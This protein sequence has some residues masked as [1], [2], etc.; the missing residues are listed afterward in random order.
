MCV[1]HCLIIRYAHFTES[2]HGLPTLRAFSGAEERFI[3]QNLQKVDDANVAELYLWSAQ[4]WLGFRLN[5]LGAVV[6]GTCGVYIWYSGSMNPAI[7]GLV[8]NY[9]SDF[10]AYVAALIT[11]L[12]TME[13]SMNAVERAGEFCALPQE[14]VSEMRVSWS[15]SSFAD[16]DAI[17]CF[18]SYLI[19]LFATSQ[20]SSKSHLNSTRKLGNA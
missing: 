14:A 13:M 5:C 19:G 17:I 18:L 16:V 3:E 7:A 20:V 6:N 4:R 15:V 12:A 8:L 10:T 1:F 2:L 9:A 11:S